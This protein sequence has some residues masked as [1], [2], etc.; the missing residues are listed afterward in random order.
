MDNLIIKGENLAVLKSLQDEFSK[1]IKLIYIDPPYNTGAKLSY[2]N[3]FNRF[4]WLAAMR[5]R[6]VEAGK[7][8]RPDGAMV[9]AIDR[10]EFLR[11]GVMLENT[12]PGHEV[13]CITIVHHARGIQ[14]LNFSYSHEYVFFVI[15]RNQKII[16]KRVIAEKDIDWRS[17]R[18]TGGESLRVVGKGRVRGEAKNCFYPIIVNRETLGIVNIGPVCDDDFHP[19]KREVVVG[20]KSYIYPVDVKGVERKW[21]YARQS[22][23]KVFDML[24]VRRKSGEL[25]VELGKNFGQFKTVWID[26]KYDA[27]VHG[28]VL[29]NRLVPGNKFSHP[30]SLYNV[31]DCVYAVTGDDKDAI[32]L[33]FYAGSGTT[34]HA[35]E[36]LNRQDG[37]NRK[38]ILVEQE[39]YIEDVTCKRM[40]AIGSKFSFLT[41]EE[42]CAREGDYHVRE[43]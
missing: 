20:D 11:L 25:D 27:S 39:S 12:F 43:F 7:L 15:P 5:E 9:V 17:L 35:V 36:G 6:L 16:S 28:T 2:K 10:R 13:H 24:R 31:L 21:R 30:K 40:V 41:R 38:Y 3:K 19:G 4:D 26:P 8:L 37:G 32:V 33:D 23:H 1:G 42:Y 34:G 22:I 14:G 18:K 29:L